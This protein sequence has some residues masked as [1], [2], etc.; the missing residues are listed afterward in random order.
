MKIKHLP[1]TCSQCKYRKRGLMRLISSSFRCSISARDPKTGTQLSIL[2]HKD[3][4]HPKCPLTHP[5][6]LDKKY[7]GKI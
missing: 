4:L 1:L 7:Y 6:H 3:F 5:K 2:P